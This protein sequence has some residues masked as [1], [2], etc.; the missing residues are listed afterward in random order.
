M[1]YCPLPVVKK[2]NRLY[3]NTDIHREVICEAYGLDREYIVTPES[4]RNDGEFIVYSTRSLIGE[5]T[6]EGGRC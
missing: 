1:F 3:R 5:Y 2:A 4:S 6:L